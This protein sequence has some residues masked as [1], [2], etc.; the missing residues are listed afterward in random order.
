MFIPSSSSEAT[1]LPQMEQGR[2]SQLSELAK[3][4]KSKNNKQLKS[5]AKEFESIFVHQLL[6]SMRSTVQKSGFFDSH[7]SNMYESLY[8]EEMSKLMT[9]QKGIGL[10]DVIY[11]DLARL[12]KKINK[13]QRESEDSTKKINSAI[14]LQG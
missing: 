2:M 1:I 11:R 8:D 12:E 9:E 13:D 4:G 6:K 5:L 3:F 10:A 14:N 7:A